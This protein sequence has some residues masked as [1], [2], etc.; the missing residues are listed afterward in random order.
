MDSKWDGLL[1]EFIIRDVAIDIMSMILAKRLR[2]GA[3]DEE[4][5]FLMSERYAMYTGDAE[6][7]EKILTVYAEEIRDSF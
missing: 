3:T 4:M 5:K 2:E 1:D 6:T 7:I